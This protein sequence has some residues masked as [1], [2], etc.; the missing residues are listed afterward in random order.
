MMRKY[1]P[2]FLCLFFCEAL[3]VFVAYGSFP[4]EITKTIASFQPGF[5]IILFACFFVFFLQ[6][7]F[8]G[9]LGG[10]FLVSVIFALILNYRWN[11]G[12]YDGDIIGGLI[13]F[14]DA[15]GYSWDAQKLILGKP[16]RHSQPGAQCLVDC[17]RFYWQSPEWTLG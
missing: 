17:W 13:P 12:Y 5:A 3:V 11:T 7:D 2:G 8:I 4:L 16:S 9:D 14:S 1:V 6:K 10:L 15:S